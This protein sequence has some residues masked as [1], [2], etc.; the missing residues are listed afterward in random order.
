MYISRIYLKNVRCFK[1]L[2]ISF[3]L[4]GRQAPWAVIVGDN[5]AGKSCLLK[6]IAIGL[7]DE[8]SAAGLLKESE[9]GYIRRGSEN[10]GAKI[11]IHLID[12]EN[13]RQKYSIDTKIERVQVKKAEAGKINVEKVRQRTFCPQKVF[14][15]QK[16]FVCA[17]GAGRGT[18]GTGDI[19]GYSAISAVY[20]MFNYSEGLQNPELAIHRMSKKF[21]HEKVFEILK[22]LMPKIEKFDLRTEGITASGPW[23][24][25]MPVR[26]LADG[27]KS[28]FVWV[29]DLIGWALSYN[30]K[31]RSSN[32]ISGVVL[33]DEIE[34]HLHPKWQHT[35]VSRLKQ[36]F[37]NIQFIAT[38]HSPLVASSVG[39]LL[40][41]TG[42]D[43]LVHL[44][45]EDKNI[46]K[47]TEL[48]CMSL[49]GLDLEQI[50]GSRAFDYETSIDPEVNPILAEA[51]KLSDKGDKRTP[52]ENRRYYRF[53]KILKEILHPE[54]RTIIERDVQKDFYVEMKRRIKDLEK[55]IR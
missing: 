21:P 40:R 27:Y 11:S 44:L 26:D 20:N 8:S 30:P 42:R 28:T 36:Q 1:E 55:N 29:S 14:P 52:S 32:Q 9:E 34:Q 15:W 23:G 22:N 51:S 49:K 35:I 53:K 18:I 7:C 13:P 12:K 4:R 2:D 16:I 19:A 38:T 48:D 45:L 39:Q 46:V 47:K 41:S 33:I 37:P 43:K 54:G 3:D 17:Y 24:E 25:Q 50:L 5:A 6:S 31:I 10:E